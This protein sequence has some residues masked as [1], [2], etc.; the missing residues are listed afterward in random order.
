MTPDRRFQVAAWAAFLVPLVIYLIT[1]AR[2][3]T[4]GDSG[5]LCA[6][7][8]TLGIAHPPGYPLFTLLG[9]LFSF[10]PLGSVAFRVGLLS[11]LSAALSSL[12]I[13]RIAVSLL[14][15]HDPHP[16]PKRGLAF[17]LA[18]LAGAFLF[19]FARTPWSQAVVIE[20]YTLQ[21]LLVLL[22]L[23]A[24]AN[25][26]ST[27]QRALAAW[28]PVA[29]ATGLALTNHLSGALLFPS[30]LLFWVIALI[31]RARG[32]MPQRNAIPFWRGLG[33]GL[34]PLL[35]YAYLPLRSRMNPPVQ[36][37]FP[38]T[39]HRFLVHVSAR[40]YHGALGR[41][42]IRMGELQRFVS[43]QLPGEATGILIGLAALGLAVLLRRSWRLA[44]ITLVT[45][46][47]FL[48]YNMAYPIPDIA[49]YY[50]PVLAIIGLW[51]AFGAG[52]LA[53]FIARRHALVGTLVIAALCLGA[54]VP[55]AAHWRENDQRGFK[56]AAYYTRDVLH[57]LDANAFLFSGS[58]DR[59]SSPALYYQLVTGVRTDVVIIDTGQISSPILGRHLRQSAPDLALACRDEIE[60]V[61]AIG[62][63]AEAGK[64]YDIPAGRERFTRMQRALVTRAVEL[65]PT[66]VTSDLHRRQ[67]L[68]GFRLITE[69]LVARVAEEDIFRPFPTPQFEGPG[70]ARHQIRN[71]AELEMFSEYGRMLRNRARY[72][73]RHGKLEEAAA[74]A[75]RAEEMSR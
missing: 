53:Q 24:I 5:E 44:L 52:I 38:E 1:L 61:A 74:A 50:I 65:R 28:P 11:S 39:L 67:M 16:D 29:L 49:L 68:R 55:L 23:A 41:E 37:D 32:S 15:R 35:L 10:L 19:A 75:R 43:E 45:A 25:A 73:E 34:L 66:Y 62:H 57:S 20:V 31:D 17:V 63:L 48:L 33:A 47:A 60:A 71:R 72:L 12:L 7:A 51:A 40:Q 9:H 13:Y 4:F 42:G 27:P 56:L 64:P 26:L 3:I 69:G 36:W 58:W 54:L 30:L 59:I 2:E 18:P 46:A 6:V 14:R 21:S 8:A 22:F 70:I